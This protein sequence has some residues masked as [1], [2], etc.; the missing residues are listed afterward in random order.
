MCGT[1]QVTLVAAVIPGSIKNQLDEL[2]KIISRLRQKTGFRI[3]KLLY[4]VSRALQP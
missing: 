2:E 4:A 3:Q 1:N